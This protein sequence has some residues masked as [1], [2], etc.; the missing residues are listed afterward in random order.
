M[1]APAQKLPIGPADFAQLLDEHHLVVLD[2]DAT[3]RAAFAHCLAEQL[4]TIPDT[5]VIDLDGGRITTFDSFCRQIDL[6]FHSTRPLRRS[7]E[8]LVR[9]LRDSARGSKHQYFIWREADG[10][11]EHDP[12]L[13]GCLANAFFAVAADRE[14]VSPDVLVL[15]RLVLLG[16]ESLGRYAQNEDGQ[17]RTWLLNHDAAPV[18]E[19]AAFMD[20]PPVLVYRM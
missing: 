11:I 4:E 13:F 8:A 20:R 1:K 19:V 17:L 18:R 6:A 16:G 3:R 10:L 12:E 15:Q 7:L 9:R 2:E 14:Y 5:E